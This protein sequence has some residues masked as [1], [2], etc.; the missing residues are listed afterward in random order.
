MKYK[1]ITTRGARPLVEVQFEDKRFSLVGEMLLAERGC[2]PQMRAS[3]E[4]VLKSADTENETFAG[5]AFSLFI[6]K[7]TT[8]LSNDING[9]EAEAPTKELS[10]LIKVYQRQYARI[11]R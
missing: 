3:L 11:K 7:E 4:K 1:I 10:R 2:L 6:T 9:E 5:N 8:K